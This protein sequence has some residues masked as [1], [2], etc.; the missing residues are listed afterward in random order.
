MGALDS[1]ALAG[2]LFLKNN[3]K[4]EGKFLIQVIADANEKK[5]MVLWVIGVFI[6]AMVWTGTSR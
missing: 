5:T 6:V 1:T 2:N 3:L 4:S